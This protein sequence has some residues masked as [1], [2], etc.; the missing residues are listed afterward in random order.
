VRGA[1]T[2]VLCRR[3]AAGRQVSGSGVRTQW[4]VAEAAPTHLASLC[5]THHL[6]LHLPQG[7]GD[8][9]TARVLPDRP[10]EVVIEGIEGDG[11]RLSL[12]APK[13]CVGEQAGSLG[14]CSAAAHNLAGRC[15]PMA[16]LRPWLHGRCK[17]AA[18]ML[19]QGYECRIL[20]A[21]CPLLVSHA[22]TSA[23]PLAARLRRHCGDRDAQAA[24][25]GAVVRR[26]PAAAQG[27]PTGQRHG[28]QRGV[29]SSGGMGR[30][31]AV[32]LP[33]ELLLLLVLLALLAL[34]LL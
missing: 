2:G 34:L 12:E 21:T 9:V 5:D 13:N 6:T 19:L 23:S 22:P 8:I 29:C 20:H 31:L 1:A 4:H 33:R 14:T 24:G 15:C 11:G 26:G 27:P 17:H 3:P 30:Q 16:Q 18:A 25:R 10:G 28:Q 32:W 7:D